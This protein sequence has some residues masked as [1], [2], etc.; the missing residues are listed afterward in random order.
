MSARYLCL[1]AALQGATLPA[2]AEWAVDPA[3]SAIR[4]SGVQVGTPFDLTGILDR[5]R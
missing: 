4:F 2:T 5:A 3:Q 1:L